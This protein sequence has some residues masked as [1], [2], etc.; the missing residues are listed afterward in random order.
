M[1]LE[2]LSSLSQIV[3]AFGVILSL[4][5]VAFQIRA[6]TAALQRNEH[7]ST[8]EQWRVI[9]QAIVQNRD[10]A[11][12]M[13]RGLDGERPMDSADQLR[14]EQMLQ[15]IGWAAFHIWDRT[16]R[17][18]FPPGTFEA[19]G[20]SMFCVVLRT[21]RGSVWWRDA[22]GVGFMPAFVADVNALLAKDKKASMLA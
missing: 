20:G 13:T 14:M 21:A 6:N 1:T 4:L 2:Q 19:T 17:G 12:F 10:V 22:Q 5:V 8:M 3:G 11:E 15:E 9:R 7:N 16:Q 18:I